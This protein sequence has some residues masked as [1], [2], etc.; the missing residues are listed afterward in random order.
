MSDKSAIPLLEKNGE[1]SRIPVHTKLLGDL[2]VSGHVEVA[3]RLEGNLHS[4]HADVTGTVIGDI[5]SGTVNIPGTV[6]GDV[7]ATGHVRLAKG[8]F[9]RGDIEAPVVIIEENASHNGTVRLVMPDFDR[10]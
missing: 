5:F 3:G 10:P 9:L 7:Y 4:G 1:T 2:N 6:K 8:C